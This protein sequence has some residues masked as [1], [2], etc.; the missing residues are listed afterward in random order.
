MTLPNFLVIG[1]AKSGTSSL[2]HYLRAHPQ[3]FTPKLKEINFFDYDGTHLDVHYWAKTL[4]EYE[5]YFVDV[6]GA[7]AIGEVAPIY[8]CSRAA[9]EN[10]SRLIPGTKLI[11]ILRNPVDRAYSDYQMFLRNRG[12]RLEP[13]RDLAPDA[14]WVR[15]DSHW[16]KI[17]RYHDQLARYYDLFPRE[18]INVFLFDDLQRNT[19]AVV[20]QIYRFLGVDPNFVPDLATP[21]NVGGMPSNVLLERI[22]TNRALRAAVEPWMSTGAANWFRRLRTKSMRKAPALPPALKATLRRQ[23]HDDISRTSTLIGR[24]L[25]HWRGE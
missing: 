4:E 6:G 9:P 24:S 14:A 23:F 18:Q 5:R 15:A 13:A 8:L 1:A 16:M 20:Q 12:R 21:H 3:V 7:M 25:D 2:H 19:L 17:G 11:A 22:L 10:I